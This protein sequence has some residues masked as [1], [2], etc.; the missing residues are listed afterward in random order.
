MTHTAIYY[1]LDPRWSLICD[2][3]FGLVQMIVVATTGACFS[4][5][6]FLKRHAGTLC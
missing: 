5:L 4:P 1:P 2:S 6:G 3:L